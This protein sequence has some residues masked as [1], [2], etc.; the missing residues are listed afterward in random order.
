MIGAILLMSV[1]QIALLQVGV[2][3][4]SAEVIEKFDLAGLGLDHPLRI[5]IERQLVNLQN[6]G[7]GIGLL[8]FIINALVL[9]FLSHR[10]AG[11]IYKIN[12][13][14]ESW[15]RGDS[16]KLQLRKGDFFHELAYSVQE[17]KNIEGKDSVNEK[18]NQL[19]NR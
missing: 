4:F 14:V 7:W 12:K 17:L 2:Y 8:L 11:P 6:T 10:I 15:L 19:R 18:R 13:V 1:C 3:R 16:T 5:F 9:L